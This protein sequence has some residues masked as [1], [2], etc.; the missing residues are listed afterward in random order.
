MITEIN[1]YKYEELKTP[2][3]F[4]I[5][6]GVEAALRVKVNLSASEIVVNHQRKMFFRSKI[7]ESI[8]G[9][10]VYVDFFINKNINFEE[11]IKKIKSYISTNP[12]ILVKLF[13]LNVV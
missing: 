13:E 4:D 9:N 3:E 12:Y 5:S 2:M 1:R 6:N 8:L 10:S 7:T 11:K